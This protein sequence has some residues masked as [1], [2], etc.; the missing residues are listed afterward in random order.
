MKKDLSCAQSPAPIN[1]YILGPQFS[2]NLR[3]IIEIT[4]IEP[5]LGHFI[6]TVICLGGNNSIHLDIVCEEMGLSALGLGPLTKY[7][8]EEIGNSSKVKWKQSM[9]RRRIVTNLHAWL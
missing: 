5:T 2:N 3:K 9:V 6:S 4:L 1:R 7:L 8:S